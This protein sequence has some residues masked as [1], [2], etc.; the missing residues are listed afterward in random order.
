M[1]RVQLHALA[2][3][4]LVAL[5]LG[6]LTLPQGLGVL[7][8]YP[9]ASTLGFLL[10]GAT[11]GALVGLAERIGQIVTVQVVI[12]RRRGDLLPDETEVDD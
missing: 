6:G 2:G 9:L 8:P 10:A 1:T 5:F 12:A 11:V 4:S 3:A 7:G